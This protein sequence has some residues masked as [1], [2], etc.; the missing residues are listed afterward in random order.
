LEFEDIAALQVEGLRGIEHAPDET[1]P[2]VARAAKPNLNP[3]VR[4]ER[5]AGRTYTRSATSRS[6]ESTV[7]PP[8]VESTSRRR[9]VADATPGR[10]RTPSA[11]HSPPGDG[12]SQVVR[13]SAAAS[14]PRATS[15]ATVHPLCS[16]GR[17]NGGAICPLNCLSCGTMV[18]VPMWRQREWWVVE[19]W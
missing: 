16:C 4:N 6:T 1:A 13:P 19:F 14:T 12:R 3:A 9:T 8:T 17:S 7:A 15:Q 18:R 2:R 10:G 11:R 5:R